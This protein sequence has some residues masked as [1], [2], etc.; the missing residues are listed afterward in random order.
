MTRDVHCGGWAN[1]ADHQPVGNPQVKPPKSIQA[2]GG[3][4][5]IGERKKGRGKNEKIRTFV[6]NCLPQSRR[7][8]SRLVTG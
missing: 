2:A 3:G 7:K 6:K 8:K 1:R 4:H 5:P